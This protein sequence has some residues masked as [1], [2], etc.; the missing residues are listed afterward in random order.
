MIRLLLAAALAAACT[1]CTA[2]DDA[3]ADQKAELIR[4][5]RAGRLWRGSCQKGHKSNGFTVADERLHGRL[6]ESC[7]GWVTPSG[8]GK[9]SPC[10]W[11]RTYKKATVEDVEEWF[12]ERSKARDKAAP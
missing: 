4:A 2:A 12:E 6:G 10:P 11:K 1:Y 8:G 5:A 9:P 3:A 7:G